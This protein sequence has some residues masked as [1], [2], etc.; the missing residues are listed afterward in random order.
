MHPACHSY[1]CRFPLHTYARTCT[2]V[3]ACPYL[4]ACDDMNQVQCVLQTMITKTIIRSKSHS[5][6]SLHSIFFL[7][8]A[9]SHHV[10]RYGTIGERTRKKAFSLPYHS[11]PSIPSRPVH[12]CTEW[13]QNIRT[14]LL[15]LLHNEKVQTFSPHFVRLCAGR[16]DFDLLLLLL[17]TITK[18]AFFHYVI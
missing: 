13:G 10:Q 8:F 6:F 2:T 15:P 3:H 4:S 17:L 9:D 1:S 11:Y 16:I 7:S 5:T 14:F 12:H 18:W